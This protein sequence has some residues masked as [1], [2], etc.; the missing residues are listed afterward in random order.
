MVHLRRLLAAAAIVLWPLAVLAQ[1]LGLPRSTVMVVDPNRLFAETAFGQRVAR[2]LEAESA[3]LAAENRRIEG[4]LTVEEKALTEKRKSMTPEEFRQ[5]ADA[6]DTKVQRIRGEQEAKARDLASNNDNAQRR[7][8]SVAQPVLQTLMTESGAE[9]LLDRRSVLL[10][11]DSVD[12]TDEAVQRI[13][14]AIG[15]GSAI[16]PVEPDVAPDQTPQ[17]QD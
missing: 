13:D 2:E 1:D 17:T 11:A 7:F 14:S 16:A 9:V 15:D 10:L 12:I 3:V 5:A 8:L 4:E 6:F